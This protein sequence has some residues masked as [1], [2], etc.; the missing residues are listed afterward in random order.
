MPIKPLYWLSGQ[1]IRG[2][3]CS[4]HE[5][6]QICYSMRLDDCSS[7]MLCCSDTNVFLPRGSTLVSEQLNMK[8]V[9]GACKLIEGCSLELCSVPFSLALATQIN[10]F[11][12][13]YRGLAKNS[14]IAIHDNNLLIKRWYHLCKTKSL[15]ILACQSKPYSNIGTILGLSWHDNVGN[16]GMPIETLYLI[17]D[18]PTLVPHWALVGMTTLAILAC[19]SKPDIEKLSFKHW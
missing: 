19:Q 3:S 5:L 2:G 15:A 12:W 1:W 18:I 16:I 4:N 7:F 9:T 14:N 6:I 11:A 10:S 8:A 17:I 13:L